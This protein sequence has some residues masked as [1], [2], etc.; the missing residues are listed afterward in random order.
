MK[1]IQIVIDEPLLRAVDRAVRRLKVKRS[2][3][4]REALHGHLRRLETLEQERR[5][6]EGYRARPQK[7]RELAAWD[8]VAAWPGR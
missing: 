7:A 4:V 2:G 5:D 6:R 3:L 8:E 1:T